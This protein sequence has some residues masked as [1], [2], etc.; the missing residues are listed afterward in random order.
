MD[1]V[2]WKIDLYFVHQVLGEHCRDPALLI[3]KQM[4]VSLTSLLEHYPENKAIATTWI[5]AVLPL[6]LDPEIKVQERVVLVRSFCICAYS[7]MY[8]TS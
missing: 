1:L 8:I 6:I 2:L 4:V 3:R 5:K 7:Y